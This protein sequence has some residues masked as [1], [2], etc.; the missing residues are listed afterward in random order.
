MRTV[1]PVGHVVAVEIEVRI[2]VEHP[3]GTLVRMMPWSGGAAQWQVVQFKLSSWT[4]LVI[5]GQERG[6]GW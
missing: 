5:V 1:K 4:V 2:L 3:Q 6:G